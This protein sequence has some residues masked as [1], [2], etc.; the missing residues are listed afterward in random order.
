MEISTRSHLRSPMISLSGRVKAK[1]SSN[2]NKKTNNK[3]VYMKD[4]FLTFLAK[5]YI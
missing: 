2:K 4:E 1:K 3:I 5:M